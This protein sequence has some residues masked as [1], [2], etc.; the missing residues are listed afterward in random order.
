MYAIRSYYAF[1]D[2]DGVRL[3]RTHGDCHGGNILWR[4]DTP[5]FVDFDDSRM[6]PAIQDRN[7][8]V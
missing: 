6:A 3:I 2:A 7:N 1:R 4:D 5:N 8:F